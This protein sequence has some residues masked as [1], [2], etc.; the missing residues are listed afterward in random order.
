MSQIAL[1]LE[2]LKDG[3]PHSVPEIHQRAGTSRLN[4]RISDLRKK[5][6]AIQCWR[7]PGKTGAAAYMYQLI[8]EPGGPE[9]PL[10]VRLTG[11]VP[12]VKQLQLTTDLIAPRTENERYRIFR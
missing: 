12:D 6:Y 11:E 8:D 2:V 10:P 7:V 3:A 9:V 4:S 5:G 1:I